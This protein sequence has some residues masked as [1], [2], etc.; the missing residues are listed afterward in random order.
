MEKEEGFSWARTPF[1]DTEGSQRHALLLL[2][3]VDASKRPASVSAGQL[4]DNPQ[5]YR[6]PTQQ[7]GAPV[8]TE[9]RR[10]TPAVDAAP[11]PVVPD[12][13]KVAAS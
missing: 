2:L 4:Q 13:A 10:S 9:V 5:Q 7:T 8:V 1:K 3:F 12:T 6:C 11:P